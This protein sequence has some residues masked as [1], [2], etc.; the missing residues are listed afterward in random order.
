MDYLPRFF[1]IF[2]I[3]LLIVLFYAVF[4][5]PSGLKGYLNK[6]A[7]FMILTKELETLVEENKNLFEEIQRFRTD[8]AYR[9]KLIREK[10]GW[11][12]DGE[13]IIIYIPKGKEVTETSKPLGK[14]E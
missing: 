9:M 14:E 5:S 12:R 2:M 1:L 7:Q 8:P 10:N 13:K 3:L 6:K 11:I 4:F